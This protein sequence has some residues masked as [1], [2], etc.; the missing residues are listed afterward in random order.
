[1]ETEEKKP[2]RFTL[3][4]VGMT[5][6]RGGIAGCCTIPCFGG[7]M[8]LQKTPTVPCAIISSMCSQCPLERV[9]PTMYKTIRKLLCI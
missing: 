1:M 9:N 4:E 5:E 8:P 6:E 2:A 3:E 7:K